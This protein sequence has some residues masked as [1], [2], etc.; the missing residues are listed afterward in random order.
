MTLAPVDNFPLDYAQCAESA[1]ENSGT[2]RLWRAD[3]PLTSIA[4]TE[5]LM[6]MIPPIARG[7]SAQDFTDPLIAH[8]RV[9]NDAAMIE[10]NLAARKAMRPARS[11]AARKGWEARRV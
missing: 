5:R 2:E 7:P 4:E 1:K 9:I 6:A 11:E 8:A 10:R 3:P